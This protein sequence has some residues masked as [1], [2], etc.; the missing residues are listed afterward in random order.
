M[1]RRRGWLETSLL[2]D[3]GI[4]IEP[5]LDSSILALRCFSESHPEM[6]DVA[7]TAIGC[8]E[9]TDRLV[10]AILYRPLGWERDSREYFDRVSVSGGS[11]EIISKDMFFRKVGAELAPTT[12]NLN[13]MAHLQELCTSHPKAFF[14]NLPEKDKKLFGDY[15]NILTHRY[16]AEKEEE[17]HN[18][19]ICYC[20]SNRVARDLFR[21]AYFL[22]L[23]DFIEEEWKKSR[24]LAPELYRDELFLEFYAKSRNKDGVTGIFEDL[25]ARNEPW[26]LHRLMDRLKK[27]YLLG[28]EEVE[29]LLLVEAKLLALGQKISGE[30]NRDELKYLLTLSELEM[31]EKLFSEVHRVST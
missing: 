25:W 29:K 26:A 11:A 16:P 4:E 21:I 17:F 20:F 18:N 7:V 15:L 9:F 8:K 22:G 5:D 19:Q 10:F 1:L 28:G 2:V 23:D 13:W 24:H 3:G 31:P 30:W 12:E 27:G 6:P 14:F